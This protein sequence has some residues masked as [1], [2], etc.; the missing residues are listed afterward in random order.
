MSPSAMSTTFCNVKN[1]THVHK[2]VVNLNRLLC[3]APVQLSTMC[4]RRL[5]GFVRVKLKKKANEIA[6]QQLMY[7][8]LINPTLQINRC[9]S[10]TIES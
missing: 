9:D 8:L 5:C 2:T 3:A 4:R 1:R 10:V 6:F 7:R